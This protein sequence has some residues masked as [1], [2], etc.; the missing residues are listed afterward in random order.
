MSVMEFDDIQHGQ[1]WLDEFEGCAKEYGVLMDKVRVAIFPEGTG[2]DNNAQINPRLLPLLKDITDTL[3][4][5]TNE[6]I[7]AKYP[8]V[9]S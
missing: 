9:Y 6:K 7:Q 2:I 5:A 3:I 1:E 8:D 4:V